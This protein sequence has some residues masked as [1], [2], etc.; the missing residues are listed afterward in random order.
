VYCEEIEKD[1]SDHPH[2]DKDSSD[3]RAVIAAQFRNYLDQ[4]LP[5]REKE[6]VFHWLYVGQ[7]MRNPPSR[8]W[9]NYYRKTSNKQPTLGFA[10]ST[11][12]YRNVPHRLVV[13][14]SD[15]SQNMEAAVAALLNIRFDSDG[16]ESNAIKRAICGRMRCPY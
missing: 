3:Y 5:L 7:T 16:K 4:K 13:V 14:S 11:L 2:P 6:Q 15:V 9:T 1:I 8:R 10:M 12:P